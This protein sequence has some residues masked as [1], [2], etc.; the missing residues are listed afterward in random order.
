MLIFA[1]EYGGISVI[2]IDPSMDDGR[3]DVDIASEG[4]VVLFTTDVGVEEDDTT[5]GTVG[6]TAS[7]NWHMYAPDHEHRK[8]ESKNVTTVSTPSSAM[9]ET[10]SG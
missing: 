4:M 3:G 1:Y 6:A 10:H 8:K 9:K 5:G 7:A 2:A